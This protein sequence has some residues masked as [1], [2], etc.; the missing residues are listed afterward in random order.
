MLKIYIIGICILII[1]I[2]ANAIIVKVG[3]KSWY[4]FIELLSQS[5][6][7]AFNK[8]SILDYLWLFIGYPLIL[9][10]GY[11]IGLKIYNLIF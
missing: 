3:L 9:G 8:L 4:D 5:G 6:T 10:L 1:A 2:L 7:E 11:L